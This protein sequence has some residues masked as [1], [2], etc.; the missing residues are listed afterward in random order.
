M[1]YRTTTSRACLL[2]SLTLAG[3]WLSVPLAGAQEVHRQSLEIGTLAQTT[4]N[5]TTEP[6]HLVS[7]PGAGFGQCT[8]H[9][10][11]FAGPL[12]DYTWGFARSLSLEGRAAY[13]PG[14][15]PVV[16]CSGGS[17]MLV[18]AGMRATL[19]SHRV[20]FYA[21]MAPGF[22]SFSQA[23][24][25]LSN[26]GPE[27]SRVTHFAL[28]EGGGAEVRVFGSNALQFDVSQILYLE[29]GRSLGNVGPFSA[30]IPSQVES[31]TIFS[32]GIAHY[33]GERL[34]ASPA[35]ESGRSFRGE[36]DLSFAL[37]KQL[38]IS[39]PT[40]LSTDTG[41][42]VSG[43]YD[44]L[45]WLG[46]DG[47]IVVLPG[48]DAPNYQDG[49]TETELLGGVRVGVERPRY[50]I[51]A[52]YRLGTASFASTFNPNTGATPPLVRFWTPANET[53][54]IFELYPRRGHFLLRLDVGEQYTYYHSVTVKEPAPPC[55]A[56][57][58][59]VLSTY[60][61]SPVVMIGGGWRF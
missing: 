58:D 50:G 7:E 43:A 21:R 51:F 39:F 35:A 1:G 56:C 26:T 59:V 9:K 38:H 27:S 45:R 54:G 42:A 37:Q 61:Y 52:K 57:T 53:G 3:T 12:A 11:V 48:G 13:L 18:T 31:H 47:S 14:K 17:A 55:S 33:F 40:P 5:K 32:A 6:C 28:D 15:Q 30:A 46:V 4:S 60:G 29:G 19:G 8:N 36:A 16:D 20:R 25:D 34:A 41:V 23:I 22:V 2:A 49:G 10:Q 24:S 44:F